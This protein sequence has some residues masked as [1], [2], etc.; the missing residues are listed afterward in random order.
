MDQWQAWAL[1]CFLGKRDLMD[2]SLEDLKAAKDEIFKNAE[3]LR[4][5]F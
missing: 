2:V 3:K 5:Q 1:S 4:T